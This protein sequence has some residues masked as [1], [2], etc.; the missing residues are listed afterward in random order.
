MEGGAC[1]VLCKIAKALAEF[2]VNAQGS[3]ISLY[4]SEVAAKS[5]VPQQIVGE[6]FRALASRGYME[7]VRYSYRKV[8]CTVS[9]NSPLWTADSRSIYQILEDLKQNL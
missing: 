2:F 1:G 8:R 7:C 4:P 3:A 5:G 9:R 6:V